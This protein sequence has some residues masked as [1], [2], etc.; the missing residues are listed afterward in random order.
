MRVDDGDEVRT[1]MSA[2][3]PLWGTLGFNLISVSKEQSI[4][5]AEFRQELSQGS[6]C[7]AACSP[8]SSDSACAAAALAYTY[9]EAYV[10]S[11]ALQVIYLRPVTAGRIQAVG[12][13]IRP[14]RRVLFCEADVFDAQG[15]LVGKGSGQMVRVP[16]PGQ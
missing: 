8:R 1:R 3:V 13:C 4:F 2:V 14:G 12:R 9:P 7:T 6:A 16:L 10:T 5:E 11:T 15:E